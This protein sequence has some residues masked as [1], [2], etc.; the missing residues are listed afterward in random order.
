MATGPTELSQIE[1]RRDALRGE[2]TSIGDLRAGSLVSR[3]R[4]CGKPGCHC[5]RPG[6]RGHGPSF[7]L[8]RVVDGRTQTTI[9]PAG[10][11]LAEAQSQ[12]GECQRLRR[13]IAEF[14]EVSSELCDAR[15]AAAKATSGEVA[16][17]RGSRHNSGKRSRPRSSSS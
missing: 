3:Y 6:D 8:T 1:R 14:I 16:E 11:A 15:L 9:I 10:P 4:K 12:I 13:V 5:A 7:S 2:L 17:K